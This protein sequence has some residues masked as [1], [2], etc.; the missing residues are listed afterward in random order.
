MGDLNTNL[1]WD[2]HHPAGENHTALMDLTEKLGLVSAYHH[3]FGEAQGAETRP[4]CYLL[5][6]RERPYHLD[7]CFVPKSWASR[8]RRVEVGTFEEW[9][10]H[11]DHRPLLVE[12]SPPSPSA[13][14]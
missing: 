10:K 9:Q 12:L 8:I 7:Y 5:W 13:R 4:T 11:S 14:G 3:F 6:K 2:S 1:F